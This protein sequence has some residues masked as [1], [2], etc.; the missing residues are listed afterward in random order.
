[1]DGSAIRERI[2][3]KRSRIPVA[4]G[5]SGEIQVRDN[6]SVI[7]KD[8]RGKLLQPSFMA[9]PSGQDN[10]HDLSITY[11]IVTKVHSGA[12]AVASGFDAFTE[13]VVTAPRQIFTDGGD[14]V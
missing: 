6:G 14:A 1:M 3:A 12:I 8:I 13:F 4:T 9:T 7:P 2:V 11:G 5:D 10:R